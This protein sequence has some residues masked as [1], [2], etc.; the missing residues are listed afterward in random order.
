M[1]TISPFPSIRTYFRGSTVGEGRGEAIDTVSHPTL[2]LLPRVSSR[3]GFC[4]VEE[5][6][7]ATPP[8]RVTS[9]WVLLTAELAE[10]AEPPL[11]LL[12]FVSIRKTARAVSASEKN[13]KTR[14]R[15]DERFAHRYGYWRP[16]IAEVVEKYLACG[17]DPQPGKQLSG[18]AVRDP[19]QFSSWQRVHRKSH[20]GG[21]TPPRPWDIR[22]T[23]QSKF[24]FRTST[25]RGSSALP[26]PGTPI[27]P[28]SKAPTL[29]RDRAPNARVDETTGP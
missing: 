11:S 21:W 16:V 1:R 15:V 25:S 7:A 12:F 2:R 29:Q 3:L 13:K 22:R 24:L 18:R 28:E 14:E 20:P 19:A 23:G 6:K 27:S 5:K 17:T 8:R 10:Y 26:H 9:G 4:R